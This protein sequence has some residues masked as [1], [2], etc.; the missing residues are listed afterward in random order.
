[1]ARFNIDNAKNYSGGA[2][3]FFS[4]RENRQTAKVRFLINDINDLFGVSCH[5]VEENGS[6]FD[7]ECLREYNEPVDKCPLCAA[8]YKP[9]AKLFIPLYNEQEQ[10][11]QVWVRGTTYFEKLSGFCARYNPLVATPFEIE[12]HGEKGD[13]N[14][15]YQLFPGRTDNSRI[16]DFPECE[17]EGTA[18]QVKDYEQMRNF[19]STGIFDTKTRSNT[20]SQGRQVPIRRTPARDDE[21]AF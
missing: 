15:E 21:E 5:E 2:S 19:V 3:N 10:K 16:T 18:F 9:K 14:T 8:G 1:M 4:L 13:P 20:T 11:S 17:I 6:K 7:V 12:R